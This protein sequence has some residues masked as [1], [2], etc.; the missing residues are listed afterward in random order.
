V[1]RDRFAALEPVHQAVTKKFDSLLST[2]M[3]EPHTT[4]MHV[5]LI[6]QAFASPRE[7]GGTRHFE[8]ARRVVA[9]G[10]KAT[11]IA[12]SLSYHSG[13][14]AGGSRR[15]IIE[16]VEVIRTYTYPSLHKSFVWRVISF[17]SFMFSSV[18]AALFVKDVDIVMGTSPPIFQALSAWFVAKL[19]GRPFLLEIRDLWPS[20]ALDIGIL[21]NPVLVFL[22]RKLEN[23]IYRQATHILVNSPAYRTYML[24]KGIPGSKVTLIPNGVDP[25]QFDAESIGRKFRDR[26]GLGDLFVAMYA[27]ALGMAND[28]ETILRAAQHLRSKPE[29]KIVLVGDGKERTN[30]EAKAKTMRISNVLFVGAVPKQEMPNALAASNVCIATLRNIPMFRMPYPNKVFDYLAAGRPI[31]LGIDGEIRKVVDNARAGIFVPPG[32]DNALA[33]AIVVLHCNRR[34]ASEMGSNGRAFVV[35][36]FNRN[37]QA[38]QFLE[39]MHQLLS[40][41]NKMCTADSISGS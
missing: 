27:G 29:I 11:I 35:A 32:D 28:I 8:F 36:N 37:T 9:R 16:G 20:F 10:N 34:M 13:G 7:A 6:H 14:Q 12:S 21:K 33:Q 15:E 39:L 38:D 5:V 22:S 25:T 41:R 4:A 2:D 30:L 40:K 1:F 19:R 31:V 23:F 24:G 3:G 18:P 17:F 26:W